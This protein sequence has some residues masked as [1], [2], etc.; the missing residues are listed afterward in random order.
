MSTSRILLVTNDFG[1]RAG[2]IETF[3][4]GLLERIGSHE[5]L[6]YTSDQKDSAPYDQK[7]LE[8]YGVRVIRDR[9]KILLPSPRVI[10]KLRKLIRAEKIEVI[11]F[12]AAAPLGLAARWLRISPVRSI[13][14]LTHGHEVW[15]S[16]V[17]LFSLLMR[18]IG[19][20][21]DTF[22]YLGDFTGSAISR[23]VSKE[24]LIKIAPGIDVQHFKPN[25]EKESRPTII[26]VGRLVH[27]KGQDRLVE[28]L[29]QIK[30]E[31]ADVE[32]VFI[33]EGPH[34]EVLDGL[35]EKHGLQENVKFLGRISYGE[36]PHYI[37]KG[38]IF[39]MPS[40]S[41]LFGLEVEGLGIVYLEASSCG[42]P[43]IAG[44]SGG[45]PDA[46]I[47]GETGYVVDG[48]NVD[49]IASRCIELLTDESLR[50]KM[51]ERGRSWVESEWSWDI[52][53][54]KFNELIRK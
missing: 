47:Q 5:V 3:V 18:E 6:V 23:V 45:A 17:P 48:E 25:K 8:E 19:K 7:W 12:G 1:P 40:R 46:V 26:S 4:I 33:G 44:S 34:R 28:A 38:D 2:G 11:W 13:V 16:K 43:V 15:W 29:A 32:L 9:S 14:A 53:S 50:K 41:R 42:L 10:H 36:L 37:S 54:G 51:G 30:R 52:W 31:I 20:S 22:G 24:K 35:V 39:A 49:E 21:V 27:R